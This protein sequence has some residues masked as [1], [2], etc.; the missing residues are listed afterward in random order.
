MLTPIAKLTTAKQAVA[1]LSEAIECFGGAGYVE[2]TGLPRLLADAQVLPIWEGTTNVLS[3]DTL[4]AM[5]KDSQSIE[6][7]EREVQ[8]LCES[9]QAPSLTSAARL[10]KAGIQSAMQWLEEVAGD[11]EKLEAGARQFALTLGRSLELALLCG[12]AQWV[13]GRDGTCGRAG[14]A[15][16]RFA[17]SGVNRIHMMCTDDAALL[18]NG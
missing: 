11:R 13:Y 1:V 6:A 12:H 10:A 8:T 4:R 18:C 3:L 15:A 2:D 16:R 14:A 17:A 9:V 5:S 7:V